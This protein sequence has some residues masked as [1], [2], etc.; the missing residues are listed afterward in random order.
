MNTRLE[1]EELK[2]FARRHV[3]KINND[4]A[5]LHVPRRYLVIIYEAMAQAAVDLG[6]EALESLEKELE[7]R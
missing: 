7:N 2:Q 6:K 3:W 4:L 1:E 5:E